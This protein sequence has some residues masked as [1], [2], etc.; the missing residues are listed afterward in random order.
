MDLCIF[1]PGEVCA[2]DRLPFVCWVIL[3][4]FDC[5]FSVLVFSLVNDIVRETS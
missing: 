3:M 5:P 2:L 4:M 1:P